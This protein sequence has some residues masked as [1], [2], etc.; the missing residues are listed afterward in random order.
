MIFGKFLA[1]A[2]YTTLIGGAVLFHEGAITVNVK[3]VDRRSGEP[4]RVF[5]VAPA[6]VVPWAVKFIPVQ[7][8]PRLP[9]EAM[10]ALPALQAAADELE[11]I[12]DAV[13][14]EVQSPREHVKIA[15]NGG[16]FTVDVVSDREEVHI[17]VPVRAARHTI[18]NLIERMHDRAALRDERRGKDRSDF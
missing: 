18:E 7:H 17:S 8:M 10:E 2:M 15:K 5:V 3:D 1:G 14:V 11:R 9:E 6:A 16:N 12:P 4:E 13:L